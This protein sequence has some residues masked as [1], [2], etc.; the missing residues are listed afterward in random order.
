MSLFAVTY[1]YGGS[2]DALA[3]HRPAHRQY[4]SD[5]E[6]AGIIVAS[7]PYDDD[8]QAGALLIVSAETADQALAHLDADPLLT[9]EVITHR[10][11]RPWKVTIGRVR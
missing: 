2:K 4:L 10:Q 3:E 5:L 8:E 7:G 11:A 1:V 6:T 9:H